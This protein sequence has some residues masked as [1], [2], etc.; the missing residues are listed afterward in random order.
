MLWQAGR[1]GDVDGDGDSGGTFTLEAEV[2]EEEC[3]G[4]REGQEAML[5]S[6]VI[7]PEPSLVVGMTEGRICYDKR[8]GGQTV[9]I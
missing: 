6:M 7:L 4:K 3:F 9:G 1:A 5:V 8:G 2:A